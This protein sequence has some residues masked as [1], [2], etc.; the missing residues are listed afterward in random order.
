M[1]YLED[2]KALK[3]AIVYAC[4]R[5]SLKRRSYHSLYFYIGF[6]VRVQCESSVRYEIHHLYG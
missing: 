4:L 1:H 3:L 5:S 2:N 6:I